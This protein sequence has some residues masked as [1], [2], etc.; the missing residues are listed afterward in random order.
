MPAF[1]AKLTPGSAI[2]RLKSNDPSLTSVDLSNNAVLQMKGKELWPQFADALA[3]NTVCTELN[4]SGC[5][6]GDF[7]AEHLG[8][9]LQKNTAVQS[10]NLENNSIGNDGAIAIAKALSVNRGVMLLNL[11]NQKGARY[12][13]T[14]LGEYLKMFDTNV[15]LLK[16]V[17]RLESRQSFRL[18]K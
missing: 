10:I 4:L 17:W 14:T 2:E 18:T 13:D 9:A 6:M 1:A 16:I 15:T 3:G 8:S 11:L 5:S 12:G 7:A